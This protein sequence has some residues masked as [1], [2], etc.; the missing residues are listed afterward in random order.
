MFIELILIGYLFVGYACKFAVLTIL[1]IMYR[2]F[3]FINR[4]FIYYFYF[5]AALEILYRG[6]LLIVKPKRGGLNA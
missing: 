2:D 4:D 1:N 5:M 3:T 6:D